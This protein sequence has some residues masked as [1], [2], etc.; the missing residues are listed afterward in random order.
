V[1][2]RAD[3]LLYLAKRN[4]RNRIETAVLGDRAN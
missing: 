4:G 2:A 1:L 3:Q